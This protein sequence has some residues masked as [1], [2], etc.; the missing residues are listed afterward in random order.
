MKRWQE[1]FENFNWAGTLIEIDIGL[2]F[3]ISMVR[4]AL[5]D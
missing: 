5:K 3:L 2:F 1:F 4:C